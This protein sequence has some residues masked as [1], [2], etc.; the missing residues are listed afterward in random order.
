M[1]VQ[2][3]CCHQDLERLIT[4]LNFLVFVLSCLF[5]RWRISY[6]HLGFFVLHISLIKFPFSTKFYQNKNTIVLS[7]LV[8]WRPWAD[9]SKEAQNNLSY[10]KSEDRVEH[11]KYPNFPF[12]QIHQLVACGREVILFLFLLKA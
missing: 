11:L 10:K 9:I 12:C 5:Y 8:P 2:G 7:D 3:G 1:V 6:L 4:S